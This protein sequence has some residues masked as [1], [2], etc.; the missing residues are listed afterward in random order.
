MK[1]QKF[2]WLPYD[3]SVATN[4]LGLCSSARASRMWA[5]TTVVEHRMGQVQGTKTG[6]KKLN[7]DLSVG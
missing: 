2:W 1:L 7:H 6:N 5:E 3:R 4:R